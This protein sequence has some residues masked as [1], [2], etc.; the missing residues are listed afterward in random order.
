MPNY[1]AQK[2]TTEVLH[3]LSIALGDCFT[4]VYCTKCD[5]AYKIL[6]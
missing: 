5:P 3:L 6:P 1:I 2:V 4:G